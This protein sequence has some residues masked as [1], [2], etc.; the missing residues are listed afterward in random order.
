MIGSFI[1]LPRLTGQGNLS[2]ETA[3]VI[4]ND[5]KGTRVTLSTPLPILPITISESGTSSVTHYEYADHVP[6]ALFEPRL[7]SSDDLF[8]GKFALIWHTTDEGTGVEHYEIKEGEGGSFARAESPYLL[9]DQSLSSII[10]VRAIDLAGNERT[11]LFDPRG[12]AS[13][14]SG[15]LVLVALLSL[16]CY[17]IWR[18]ITKRI[19]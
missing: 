15:P 13:F 10:Y 3:K 14:A 2:L 5:G 1:F 17:I 12:D 7:V 11:V 19:P 4:R 8:D 16:L 9:E 6:P 18:L